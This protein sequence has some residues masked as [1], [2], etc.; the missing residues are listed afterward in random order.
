VSDIHGAEY[1]VRPTVSLVVNARTFG[2]SLTAR[3]RTKLS[4]LESLDIFG[5]TDFDV[6]HRGAA[7]CAG[8]AA[9]LAVLSWH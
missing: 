8:A 3:N 4:V 6:R 9:A 1:R 2:L 5:I 7:L